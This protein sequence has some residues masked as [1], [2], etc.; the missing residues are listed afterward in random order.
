[1]ARPFAGTRVV[2]V[3]GTLAVAAATKPLSDFGAEVLKVEPLD[4]G[5]LRR[6]PPFPGDVP[7]RDRGGY[8]LALDTGKRSLALDPATPGERRGDREQQHARDRAR[9]DA[10]PHARAAARSIGAALS[11]TPSRRRSAISAS[12]QPSSASSAS[13]CWPASTPGP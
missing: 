12:V 8:H 2:E 10:P 5:D 13:V 4:G 6:L 11:T 3:G 7:H 9:S 1:M